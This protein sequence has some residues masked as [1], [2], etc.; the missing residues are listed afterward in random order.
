MGITQHNGFVNYVRISEG[1]IYRFP[2]LRS[3][4]ELI[5]Q[6][7]CAVIAKDIFDFSVFAKHANIR[8]AIANSIPG[9][10]AMEKREEFQIDGRTFHKPDFPT[11]NGKAFFRVIAIPE[12]RQ[13]DKTYRMTSVRSEGQFNTIIYEQEDIYREQARCLL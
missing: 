2:E 1:G 7:A 8:D 3:E 5:N 12:Y 13:T 9:F 11:T 6:L 4:V 10:E